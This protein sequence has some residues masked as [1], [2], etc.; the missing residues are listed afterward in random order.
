VEAE[1]QGDSSFQTF[2]L[3]RTFFLCRALIYVGLW[4]F[5]AYFLV[6]GG[7]KED[8]NDAGTQN[9]KKTRLS[10][11]FLVVYALTCWLAGTDWIMSLEPKW[12]STIF[13]VYQFTGMFLSALAAVIVLVLWLDR[14]GVFH[15]SLTRDHLHDLGTLLFAFS[16]FWMYIW[17]S[18][19]L[20]IWYVNN[21]EETAYFVL[22][23]YETWHPLFLANLVLNWGIPFVVL[24]F[25][26]A[27]ESKG[28][29][30]SVAIIVLLGRWV[31]LYLMILPPVAGEGAIFGLWDAGLLL[32][33][34]GLAG[35]IL[36]PVVT[37]RETAH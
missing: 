15:G 29:L 36:S 19:Y 12:S 13:G 26:P 25:R 18:Q 33:A 17:F 35:L 37:Q 34:A 32:G 30:L 3:E 16:S 6:R 8:A 2:W 28:V 22:R 27:K 10:A 31:D 14:R 5:F 4:L 1:G 9:A 7:E 24:L 20:L 23:Q 21:P 11:V